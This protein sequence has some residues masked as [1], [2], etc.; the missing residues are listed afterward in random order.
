[1]EPPIRSFVAID[2]SAP[3]RRQIEALIEEL[4]KSDAQVGWV[5][6]EG[7]HLTLKFLGNVAPQLIE[8][9]KPALVRAVG[10]TGPL[11]IEAAGCGAFPG[12]KSP[13]VIWVGLRGQTDPLADLARR[14]KRRWS[15]WVLSPKR[16]PLDPT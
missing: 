3:V 13:R 6:S 11:P 9:I 5:G 14:W 4:R 10:Q 12:I 7:I 16:V 2:L 15:P 8:Q 1:M